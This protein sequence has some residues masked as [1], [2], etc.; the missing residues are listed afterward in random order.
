MKDRCLLSMYRDRNTG[1][2]VVKFGVPLSSINDNMFELWE[3]P[4]G[5]RYT[6]LYGGGIYYKPLL[7]Y[8]VGGTD[9]D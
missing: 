3:R 6:A 4:D 7:D 5:S 8:L 9:N 2:D 1:K